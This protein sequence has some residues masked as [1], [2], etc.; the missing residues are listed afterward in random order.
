MRERDYGEQL[1]CLVHNVSSLYAINN[2]LGSDD[3]DRV[4]KPSILMT[5]NDELLHI[6]DGLK[7]AFTFNFDAS[8]HCICMY[9][10]HNVCTVNAYNVY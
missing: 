8:L 2:K 1:T 9:L 6:S 5:E 10:I 7:A 4:Y 3:Q